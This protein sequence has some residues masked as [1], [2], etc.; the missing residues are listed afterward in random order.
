MPIKRCTPGYAIDF[1][2]LQFFGQMLKPSQRANQ[3]QLIV[4]IRLT[5][6]HAVAGAAQ[7]FKMVIFVRMPARHF[8]LIHGKHL[9][10]IA[11]ANGLVLLG[12]QVLHRAHAQWVDQHPEAGP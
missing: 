1:D 11:A 10:D 12:R 7:L 4:R 5:P 8:G 3:E 2:Q 6:Q 9:A